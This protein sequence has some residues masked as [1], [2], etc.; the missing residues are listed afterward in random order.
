[1]ETNIDVMKFNIGNCTIKFDKE[2]DTIVIGRVI[3]SKLAELSKSKYFLKQFIEMNDWFLKELEKTK[4]NEREDLYFFSYQDDLKKILKNIFMDIKYTVYEILECLDI[5]I[6][7]DNIKEIDEDVEIF[8][9]GALESN[10]KFFYDLKLDDDKSLK[11]FIRYNNKMKQGGR[12]SILL[13]HHVL[14]EIMTGLL[15]TIKWEYIYD[16]HP[17]FDREEDE[18]PLFDM[19]CQRYTYFNEDNIFYSRYTNYVREE[20]QEIEKCNDK[21]RINR[22]IE[23]FQL[24]PYNLEAYMYLVEQ[25][26]DQNSEIQRLYNTVFGDDVLANYKIEL[27]N[28]RFKEKYPQNI[29]SNIKSREEAEKVNTFLIGLK[30]YYSIDRN[31]DIDNEVQLMM[32]SVD[33]NEKTVNG[34]LYTSKEEADVI[35]NCLQEFES[36][37]DK[38]TLLNMKLSIDKIDKDSLNPEIIPE[39]EN[40]NNE[41]L[42]REKECK[43]CKEKYITKL[44]I[45][46]L[47]IYLIIVA[48]LLLF[49]LG[50]IGIIIDVILFVAIL[51]VKDD[52]KEIVSNKKQYVEYEK[53]FNK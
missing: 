32:K 31:L 28:E 52:I 51:V 49:A 21:S 10:W 20:R 24:T 27:V 17:E 34:K 45:K 18:N 16:Q 33:T 38:S 5:S 26:G 37:I 14:L 43:E 44:L 4:I 48:M 23:T 15:E 35:R 42:K 9:E 29:I 1:M 36:K 2:I 39:W 3:Y 7:E 53:Y 12:E 8:V 25:I 50:I 47:I 22:Y 6:D 40:L 41:F 11:E 46:A 19:L 13:C 30:D